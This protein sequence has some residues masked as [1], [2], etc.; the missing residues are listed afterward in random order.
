[1]MR[2]TL[3]LLALS[4]VPF[5]S[6]AA[7]DGVRQ[8]FEWIRTLEAVQEQI[9]Q[10]SK[11][12][13][14][15]LPKL[16]A[17]IAAEIDKVSP[18]VMREPRNV[19]AI[20]I[21]TLGGGDGR[22]ARKLLGLGEL[23]PSDEKVAKGALAYVEGKYAEAAEQFGD[24][25]PRTL[26][27]SLAGRVALIQSILFYKS[28]PTKAIRF[29][30]LARL[31]SAGTLVEE[32]A[33]RRQVVLEAGVRNQDRFEALSDQY[34]RKY[35]KSIYAGY[36]KEQF[37]IAAAGLEFSNS[38]RLDRLKEII[39]NLDEAEQAALFV[40]LAE[41][42]IFVGNVALTTFAA[43]KAEEMS[44]PDSAQRRRARLY[45]A[46]ADVAMDK[47]EAAVAQLREISPS[48]LS[49]VDAG[50]QWAALAVANEV[51]RAPDPEP[52]PVAAT[53]A[54]GKEQEADPHSPKDAHAGPAKEPATAE[55][56]DPADKIAD[57][58]LVE[59]AKRKMAE[60]DLLLK[61]K[62]K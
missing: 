28:D 30:N 41:K 45:R 3:A 34:F 35:K 33:L 53:P 62:R 47:P 51:M 15:Y 42:A 16:N 59:Y 6:A 24:V 43:K 60:A 39:E 1:M 2:R 56:A 32:A 9:G 57:D 17:E 55:A 13:Y 54:R 27:A 8:P 4:C 40:L 5:A 52:V 37:S 61:G 23:A 12:A 49:T 10:G 18:E 29:L 58:P 31:F 48:Q 46:S 38:V 36:F 25:D 20:L 50:L 7:D 19:R 21:Y 11:A 22:V 14:D 26:D 44:A